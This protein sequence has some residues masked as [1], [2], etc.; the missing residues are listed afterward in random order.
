MPFRVGEGGDLG[1]L[2]VRQRR[3]SLDQVLDV[4]IGLHS[5]VPATGD[6]RV[7]DR[8]FSSCTFSTYEQPVFLSH[9][10]GTDRVLDKIVVDLQTSVT[11]GLLQLV[12]QSKDIRQGLPQQAFGA[13]DDSSL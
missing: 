2:L 7:Q 4:C 8:A 9:R 3:H 12:P 5:V 6:Q 10:R 1:E 11:K 13:D